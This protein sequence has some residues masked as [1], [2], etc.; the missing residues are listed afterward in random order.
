MEKE[1]LEKI[2]KKLE[3]KIEKHKNKQIKEDVLNTKVLKEGDDMYI[4]WNSDKL[5][6]YI[7]DA[8][9]EDGDKINISIN[10]KTILFDYTTRKKERK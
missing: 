7:W 1:K 8:N 2:T 10:D 4:Q 3:K 6:I 9:T 5:I